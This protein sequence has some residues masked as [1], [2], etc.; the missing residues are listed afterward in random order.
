MNSSLNKFGVALVFM[1]VLTL[2][3]ASIPN[4]H[5]V[6]T[7][8]PSPTVNLVNPALS[9]KALM[10]MSN[11]AGL[12]MAKYAVQ[13]GAMNLS[14]ISGVPGEEMIKYTLTATGN[15][16]DVD[17]IFRNNTLVWCTLYP[18]QGSPLYTQSETDAFSA[19]NTILANYQNFSQ[20]SYIPTIKSMLNSAT[21]LQ[22][23][24]D[25]AANI[26]QQIFTNGGT[27]SMQWA[28]TVNDIIDNFKVVS[29]TIQN[30]GLTFFQDNWNFFTVGNANVNV[31]EN[32]AI[33]IAEERAQSYSYTEGGNN[34]TVSNFTFSNEPALASLS[35]QERG[36]GTLYPQWNMYL[37]LNG[38]YP[39]GVTSIHV[40]E[41]ADTGRVWAITA[42]GSGGAPPSEPSEQKTTVVQLTSSSKPEPTE[43]KAIAYATLIA[44]TVIA[45]YLIYKRRR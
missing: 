33:Q 42:V 35:M 38:T 20:T 6:E 9:Q 1:A 37:P 40:L 25:T 11:V 19:A 2:S 15:Q 4:V 18:I 24:T 13:T 10:F 36:N 21:Q 16:L 27:A 39:D 28:Y 32:E 29:L 44:A 30:G 5:S 41:W 26:V 12:D 31:P 3:A 14:A 45:S 17:F 22:N 8:V 43:Y 23:T 7:N 34:E